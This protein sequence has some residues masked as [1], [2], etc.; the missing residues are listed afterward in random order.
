MAMSLKKMTPPDCREQR[1]LQV[2]E[3]LSKC[4]FSNGHS[5]SRVIRPFGSWEIGDTVSHVGQVKNIA[6]LSS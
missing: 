1:K 3:A 6:E 2:S 4:V 5:L